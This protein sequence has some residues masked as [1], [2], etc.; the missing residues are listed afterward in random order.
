M[1]KI[2]LFSFVLCG[3]LL[4]IC[5]APIH[6]VYAQTEPI[7]YKI[8]NSNT[9]FFRTPDNIDDIYFILPPTYFV[10]FLADYNDEILNVGYLDFVGF[11]QKSDVVRVYSTPK[12]PYLVD[13]VFSP[14]PIANLVI[15]ALPSTQSNF[16]GTI[17]YN[18]KDITYFGAIEGEEANHTLGN[19]WYFCRYTS[20]EQGTL[21]GY[22]YAALTQNLSQ[23]APNDEIVETNPAMP[24]SGEISISPELQSSSNLIFILLITIPAI[25]ILVLIFRSHNRR[26]KVLKNRL[27]SMRSLPPPDELDF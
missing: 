19:V 8:V 21:T 13:T 20:P 7:F 22:V 25:F 18:A 23:I 1:P 15:R 9:S 24:V 5:V 4:S 14:Q 17:P 10:K 2:V 26:P 11:V 16:V 3:F 12:T 27:K 6:T